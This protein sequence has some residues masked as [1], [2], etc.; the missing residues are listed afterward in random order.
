MIWK[1]DDIQDEITFLPLPR[2]KYLLELNTYLI[3]VN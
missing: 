2:L 3:Y 1:E